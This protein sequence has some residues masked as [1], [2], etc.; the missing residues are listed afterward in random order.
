MGNM[1]IQEAIEKMSEFITIMFDR[2]AMTERELNSLEETR[3]YTDISS[4]NDEKARIK[5]KMARLLH[6]NYDGFCR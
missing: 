6:G 5:N 1:T 4:Y 3:E 2:Q